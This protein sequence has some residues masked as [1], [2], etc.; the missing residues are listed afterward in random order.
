MKKTIMV[1][2]S[3][4]PEA[5]A[6]CGKCGAVVDYAWGDYSFRYYEQKDKSDICVI[7][8]SCAAR[9]TKEDKKIRVVNRS[10]LMDMINLRNSGWKSQPSPGQFS[11]PGAGGTA[12]AGGSNGTGS[13][14]EPDPGNKENTE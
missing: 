11:A 4:R 9:M 2:N 8:K 5:S 7:C 10:P 13:T 1:S 3:W 6:E 14:G 12:G